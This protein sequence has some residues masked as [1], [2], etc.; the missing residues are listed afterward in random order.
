MDAAA[1]VPRRPFAT[2]HAGGA[3]RR[4]RLRAVRVQL[5]ARPR[6]GPQPAMLHRAMAHDYLSRIV[7]STQTFLGRWQNSEVI[8]RELTP[9]LRVLLIVL[10]RTPEKMASLNLCIYVPDPLWMVRPFSWSKSALA[11]SAAP[12]ETTEA[13]G[14]SSCDAVLELRDDVVGFRLLADSIEVKENVRLR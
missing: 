1:S 2:A 8:L 14:V 13:R 12:V 7:Q 6:A 4:S 10:F 11:V 9:S 3:S 5:L